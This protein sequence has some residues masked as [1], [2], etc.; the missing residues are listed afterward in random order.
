[1]QGTVSKIFEIREN[2]VKFFF[3]Y[4]RNDLEAYYKYPKNYQKIDLQSIG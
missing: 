3:L 4:W 2:L 1:M